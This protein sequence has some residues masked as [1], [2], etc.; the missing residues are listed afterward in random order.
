MG[1]IA[2]ILGALAMSIGKCITEY[3]QLAPKIFEEGLHARQK[4]AR[5]FR[6]VQA[7]RGLMHPHLRLKFR[8][9]CKAIAN[10]ILISPRWKHSSWQI[11]ARC[12]SISKKSRDP[13]SNNPSGTVCSTNLNVTKPAQLRNYSSPW[14]PPVDCSIWQAARATSAA[15]LFFDPITFGVRPKTYGDG[16]LHYNNPIRVLLAKRI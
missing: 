13:T 6:K 7:K 10:W 9:W 8:D 5:L 1:L 15:L 14:K 3:L 16:A 12:E 4:P 2:I 11:R